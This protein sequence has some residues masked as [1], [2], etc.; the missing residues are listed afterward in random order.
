MT[1]RAALASSIIQV[2]AYYP[3]HLGGQENAVHGLSRALRQSGHRVQ[4][5]TS[6]CGGALA[7]STCEDG[8]LVTRLRSV[9]F[10]HTAVMPALLS[11][12]LRD[13]ADS[14]V[15]LHIGQAFVP[16]VAYLASRLKKF[17]YIVQLHTDIQPSGAVGHLLP[18]YKRTVLTRVIRHASSV[19]V[20]N[21]DF[22]SILREQ[23]DYRGNSVHVHNGIADEWFDVLP[24]RRY[25][26]RDPLQLLFVG[27]L[28]PRKNLEALLEAMTEFRDGSVQ[29][30]VIGGGPDERSCRERTIAKRLNH[31]VSFTGPLDR[32][33]IIE[34][35]RTADAVVV[36]SLHE[37]QPLVMLECM[38]AGIPTIASDVPGVRDLASHCSEL[39]D[40]TPRGIAQAI[41]TFRG[42]S[43]TMIREMVERGRNIAESHRWTKVCSQYE[44]IYESL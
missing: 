32:P 33:A 28:A 30:R 12:L 42:R 8:V 27:R 23:Y 39:T 25:E 5:L 41:R 22:K 17:P 9:E 36:P 6:D 3:P 18:A 16:E 20:L 26:I 38:A 13:T 19:L 35:M 14:L 21:K 11:R 44:A 1:D 29:L 31:I 43:A 4:V 2:S 37:A 40:T 24:P 10:G 7:G 34:C 15:H